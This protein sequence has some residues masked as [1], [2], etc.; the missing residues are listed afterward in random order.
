M[1]HIHYRELIMKYGVRVRVLGDLTLLPKEVL[2]QIARAVIISKDNKNALL[3][4]CFAYSSQHEMAEAV[5]RMATGVEEGL[6][7]PRYI[8]Q[9]I[10]VLVL[11]LKQYRLTHYCPL[12]V[13]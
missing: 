1:D 10:L 12:C 5:K 6:L 2:E 13:L 9:S 11:G 8:S 3:N 4:V 7:L